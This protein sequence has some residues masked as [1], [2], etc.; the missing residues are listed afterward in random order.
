MTRARHLTACGRRRGMTVLEVVLAIGLM[1]MVS[2]MMFTFYDQCLRRREVVKESISSGYLARAIAHKIADEIRSANGFVAQA[3]P[4][5]TG[6]ERMITLQTIAIP[7]RKVFSVLGIEDQAPPAECDVRQVQYYLAYDE[8]EANYQY[9]DGT[10]GAAPMGL[11]RREIKTLYQVLLDE[12]KRKNVDLDLLAPE[13]K[14]LRFRYFDGVEW[15]DRWDLGQQPE[16]KLGNSLPQAVEVTIGYGEVPPP[17]VEEEEELG[18]S[19]SLPAPPEPYARDKYT[20]MVRLP[21][22]DTF[23]GSRMMRAQRRS[24]MSSA[25]SGE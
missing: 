10:T 4:G 13:I 18:D 2:V 24:R 3:G 5:I 21:Q 1:V 12:T 22:A 20:I 8:D 19:D 15:L 25:S 23:F 17:D 7:D 6:K 9:A 16:G 11:V 14:Y